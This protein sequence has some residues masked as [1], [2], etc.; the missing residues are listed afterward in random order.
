MHP[1]NDPIAPSVSVDFP[2]SRRVPILL[3]EI[4]ASNL[5]IVGLFLRRL[6]ITDSPIMRSLSVLSFGYPVHYSP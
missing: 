3:P 4:F 1:I 6:H 5:G 2:E